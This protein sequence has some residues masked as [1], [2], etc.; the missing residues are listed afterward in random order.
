[1]KYVSIEELKREISKSPVWT[2]LDVMSR[3]KVMPTIDIVRCKECRYWRNKHGDSACMLL[4]A[5]I[6]ADDF[7]SHGERKGE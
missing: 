2:G 5:W 1:M 4:D 6:N 3:I 7:C